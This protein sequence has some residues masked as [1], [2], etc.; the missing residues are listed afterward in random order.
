MTILQNSD[1]PKPRVEGLCESLR[2]LENR[3]C[4]DNIGWDL[5]GG[6]TVFLRFQVFI[7]GGGGRDTLN[8]KYPLVRF[9]VVYVV[10]ESEI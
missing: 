10:L 4:C 1:I 9:N 7:F 8:G 6:G 5:R 2:N 3:A